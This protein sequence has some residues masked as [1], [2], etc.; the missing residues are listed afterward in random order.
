MQ[1]KAEVN[2]FPFDA[3]ALVLLLLED[4]HL[5]ETLDIYTLKGD[6]IN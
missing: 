1:V 5:E 6:E 4:E 2:E 3:L